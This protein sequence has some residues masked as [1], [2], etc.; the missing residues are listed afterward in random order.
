MEFG[1]V[2]GS[3]FLPSKHVHN[4]FS[5]KACGGR[6]IYPNI[7]CGVQELPTYCLLWYFFSILK[8]AVVNSVLR[9][10]LFFTAEV[11]ELISHISRLSQSPNISTPEPL[12]ETSHHPSHRHLPF[13]RSFSRGRPYQSL[14][15]PRRRPASPANVLFH[16]LCTSLH[17]HRSQ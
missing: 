1:L 6:S 5:C 10:S 17:D 9:S 16:T 3:G 12:V 13:V 2:L 4:G 8:E 14:P 15:Y 7:A 11:D